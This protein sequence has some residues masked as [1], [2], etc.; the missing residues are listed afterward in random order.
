MIGRARLLIERTLKGK[1]LQAFRGAI[2][3]ALMIQIWRVKAPLQTNAIQHPPI[4]HRES[5][6]STFEA[7][8]SGKTLRVAAC[9]MRFLASSAVRYL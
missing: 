9:A 3:H 8:G 6:Q 7:G 5:F 4:A 1:E 2:R